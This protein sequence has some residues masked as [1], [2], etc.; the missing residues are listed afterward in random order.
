MS[1]Q[2]NLI[3]TVSGRHASQFGSAAQ[4]TFIQQGGSIGRAD[5]CDWVLPAS[6]VS[7]V[8]AMVRY[9]NGMYFIEDRSTN[10]M[11]L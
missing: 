4:K 10:G 1:S 9:L 3:L 6:G 7:R 5:D 8:H 2:Q 11:L